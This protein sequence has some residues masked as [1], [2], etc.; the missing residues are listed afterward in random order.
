MHV[1]G[2]GV[3]AH[4]SQPK[5]NPL[6][7]GGVALEKHSTT[8][9]FT[10]PHEIIKHFSKRALFKRALCSLPDFL[11][12]TTSRPPSM[13]SFHPVNYRKRQFVHKMF[14]HN[15]CAP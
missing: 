9:G 11:A 1:Q 7:L 5:N 15:F 4:Q 10:P 6:N 8:R 14:V 2:G 12:L 13:P 3:S